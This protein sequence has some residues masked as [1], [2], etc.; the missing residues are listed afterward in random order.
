[1]LYCRYNVGTCYYIS[2]FFSFLCIK[3]EMM[4]KRMEEVN[5][6]KKGKH[7]KQN[8]DKSGWLKRGNLKWTFKL[9]VFLWLTYPSLFQ[10]HLH[11]FAEVILSIS[12]IS[13]N[14]IFQLLIDGGFTSNRHLY[15]EPLQVH[16]IYTGI[17]D[18]CRLCR[19]W[20]IT[21]A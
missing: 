18:A 17:F 13:S 14:G 1:M 7:M 10:I 6:R 21:K 19:V 15:Y 5:T 3:P 11:G 8:K 20:L 16:E 12:L 9:Y 2:S 4:K